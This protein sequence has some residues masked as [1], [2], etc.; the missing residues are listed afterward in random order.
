MSKDEYDDLDDLLVDEDPSALD[1]E[2][3]KEA[4]GADAE[5]AQGSAAASGG[6]NGA[7]TGSAEDSEEAKMMKDLQSEFANLLKERAGAGGDGS[8]ADQEAIDSFNNLINALG[9]SSAKESGADAASD[10]KA[11]DP[12]FKNVI[13]DTLGRLKESG[14]KIDSTL[15]E[16]KDAGASDDLLSQLLGQLVDGAGAPGSNGG[17]SAN[18]ENIDFN[19]DG[20]DNAILNILNQM[21]S[22]E[23]LY[24]PMVEMKTDF[25]QWFAEHEQEDEHQAKLDV[26][27]KQRALVEELVAV[28]ERED[29]ENALFRDEVTNILD[30][31][32]A[33]GDSPVSKGF[34]NGA[35]N[36]AGMDDL[37][38]LLEVDGAGADFGGLD[39]DM[40]EN[41]KQQ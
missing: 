14:S 31:L 22:K 15:Q 35:V 37:S 4:K 17:A 38:K 11:E 18:G 41:C 19:E 26:Y 9:K 8:A 33:L 20:M 7:A 1:A 28:Y 3:A 23:V 39:K 10:E 36:D 27:R 40:A 5:D 2:K 32:E 16:E 13:A 6:A 24:E 29:Y 12:D 21:S 25:A 34:N 30:E